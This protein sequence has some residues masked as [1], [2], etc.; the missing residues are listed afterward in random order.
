MLRRLADGQC[1]RIVQSGECAI[2]KQELDLAA[3]A[4]RWGGWLIL[5]V[6]GK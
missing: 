6:Q 5:G 1:W 2:S 3:C 4:P